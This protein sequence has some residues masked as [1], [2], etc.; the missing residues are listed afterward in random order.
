MAQNLMGRFEL[1]ARPKSLQVQI[2]REEASGGTTIRL[3]K[4]ACISQRRQRQPKT[5]ADITP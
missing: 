2:A 4:A 5:V 3:D 1:Q